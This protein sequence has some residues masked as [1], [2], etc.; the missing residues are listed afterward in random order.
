MSATPRKDSSVESLSLSLVTPRSQTVS[1]KIDTINTPGN[2]Q[3]ARAPMSPQS[4]ED[5]K[6]SRESEILSPKE[7]NLNES[8]LLRKK[9]TFM[10]SSKTISKKNFSRMT[11]D[12]PEELTKN[13]MIVMKKEQKSSKKKDNDD[14]QLKREEELFQSTLLLANSEKNMSLA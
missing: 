11:E 5:G 1:P 8:Q 7:G 14:L 4:N 6:K 2:Q 3:D 10:K 12:L 9:K 13:L